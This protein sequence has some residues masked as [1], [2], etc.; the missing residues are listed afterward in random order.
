MP[1]NRPPRRTP[2]SHSQEQSWWRR[3]WKVI[4]GAILAVSVAVA[5]PLIY[6]AIKGGTKAIVA[7]GRP[8]FT[9]TTQVDSLEDSPCRSYV[10]KSKRVPVPS[11]DEDWKEWGRRQRGA[12]AHMT[13]I[14]LTL[15]GRSTSSV[16]L[17]DLRVGVESK[18][19]PEGAL[20]L[21]AGGCGGLASRSF[22]VNLDDPELAVVAKGGDDGPAVDFP[23]QIS[24][25]DPEVFLVN[26][27]TEKCDCRFHLDL[28]WTSGEHK[29]TLRIRDGKHPFHVIGA[30]RL[31]TFQLYPLEGKWQPVESP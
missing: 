14:R 1:S 23:Y 29:G 10:V 11:A 13:T 21:P 9:W 28:D 7:G 22:D 27:H 5:G 2:R 3:H 6:D 8:P 17:H 4:W 30:Q 16:V 26:V 20:Y 24:S 31:P 25:G 18:R 15:Q 19:R 12:A